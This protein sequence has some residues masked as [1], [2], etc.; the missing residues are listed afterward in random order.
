[1]GVAALRV[2]T[3]S[4]EGVCTELAVPHTASYKWQDKLP[5]VS[6]REVH[7]WMYNFCKLHLWWYS[8]NSEAL[9]ILQ[10]Y[11]AVLYL[12]F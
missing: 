7:K 2:T 6:G 3:S 5:V 11:S 4:A 10:I 12:Y 9:T 8:A 1:M